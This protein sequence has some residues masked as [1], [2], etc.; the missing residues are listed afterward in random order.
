MHKKT[1]MLT[2]TGME[3]GEWQGFLKTKSGH[4]CPFRTT[5]EMLKEIN[6]RLHEEEQ[7]S[8]QR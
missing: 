7:K 2:V 6:G 1:F 3:N 4:I 8:E 5:L